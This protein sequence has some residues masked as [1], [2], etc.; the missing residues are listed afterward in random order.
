[1]TY[2][3][4]CDTQAE[5]DEIAF[6]LETM[7]IMTHHQIWLNNQ[8]QEFKHGYDAYCLGEL[9][10]MHKSSQWVLGYMQAVEDD[11]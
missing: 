9:L 11:N 4:I 2:E 5:A 3:I 8:S 7:G 1:M 10:D 6:A